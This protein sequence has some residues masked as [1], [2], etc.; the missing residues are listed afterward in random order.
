LKTSPSLFVVLVLYRTDISGSSTVRSLLNQ[1]APPSGFL[2]RILLFDNSPDKQCCSLAPCWD[3]YW[4]GSNLGLAGAYN[5]ALAEAR[6]VKCD[7]LLLLD[8][9][10][11][12]HPEF[13]SNLHAGLNAIQDHENVVACVPEVWM[14]NTPISPWIRK[15]SRNVS[16]RRKGTFIPRRIGAVNSGTCVRTSF[17]D[18]LGGFDQRFWLDF[19]DHWLFAAIERSGNSISIADQRI[20]HDLS[21]RD[22]NNGV[23]LERYR[24]ILNAES[25]FTRE[26]LETFGRLAFLGRLPFRALR[27]FACV[28]DKRIAF[29]TISL[30]FNK[31][32][33]KKAG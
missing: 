3:Y 10:T 30:L 2:N 22:Y 16:F 12:L 11:T 26:Y 5:F 23:S 28:R 29:A 24:N 27:Q 18:G 8:Q 14:G 13:L 33:A 17:V 32:V 15:W 1:R 19:L 7:W 21:V 4:P 6:R 20:E 31:I 9:D 25:L